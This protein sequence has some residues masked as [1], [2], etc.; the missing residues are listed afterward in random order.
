[1]GHFPT[2]QSSAKPSRMGRP[3]L[4]VKRMVIRLTVETISRIEAVAGKRRI[5]EF[6]RAAVLAE[7]THQ[8]AASPDKPK[9]TK[10]APSGDK[11]KRKKS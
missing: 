7:L 11:P 1:M 8:E 9:P 4:N 2:S 5:A 10:S 3:P 6:V